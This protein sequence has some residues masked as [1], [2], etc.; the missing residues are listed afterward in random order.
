M[1]YLPDVSD[2][3]SGKQVLAAAR[4][5]LPWLDGSA[6]RHLVSLT[7]RTLD[8]NHRIGTEGHGCAGGDFDAGTWINADVGGL[9][10]GNAPAAG[11][12]HSFPCVGGTQ[13]ETVH[14][15][16]LGIRNVEGGQGRARQDASG[17]TGK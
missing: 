13:C 5:M 11:D 8:G 12:S 6:D 10:G 14:R 9:P 16:P 3:A 2:G 17:S 15:C 1:H 7:R 4:D